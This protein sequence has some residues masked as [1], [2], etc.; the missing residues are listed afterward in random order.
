MVQWWAAN[1]EKVIAVVGTLAGVIGVYFGFKGWKRKKP[2]YLIYSNNIFS[3]LE[4]T[5]P[6]VEV[7]FRGYGQQIKALTVTKIAFWNA[8]TETIRRQDVVK[9]DPITIQ[10]KDGIVFLSAGVIESVSPLNKIDCKVNQDRSVVTITFEYLDRGQ[11]ANIQIFHTGSA[12]D[13]ITVEGTIIGALPLR[14]VRRDSRQPPLWPGVV[15]VCI[16]WLLWGL[17]AIAE[18]FSIGL[19][20]GQPALRQP[21]TLETA[22]IIVLILTG[23]IGVIVYLSYIPMPFSKVLRQ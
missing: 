12:S 2:T 3:G 14:R 17:L 10:A 18:K 15:G 16:L 23:V 21:L 8:G 7:K 1:W 4:H 9:D 20:S 11:G 6:D 22:G 5:V 19:E 13:D